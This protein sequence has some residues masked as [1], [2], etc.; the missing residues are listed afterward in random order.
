MKFAL[1]NGE[2][3]EAITTYLK[4]RKGTDYRDCIQLRNKA[5]S[6]VITAVREFERNIAGRVSQGKLK[7]LLEIC[8]WKNQWL[9]KNPQFKE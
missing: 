4:S 8:E 5:K 7:G 6:A 1:V 2:K 3:K 9:N